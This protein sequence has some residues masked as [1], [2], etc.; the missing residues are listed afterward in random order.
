M[1]FRCIAV[2]ILSTMLPACGEMSKWTPTRGGQRRQQAQP[3]YDA[4]QA[5]ADLALADALQ[6][7]ANLNAMRHAIEQYTAI[8]QKRPA[9]LDELVTSGLLE[10]LPAPPNGERYSY[11]PG[12]GTV[13][14]IRDETSQKGDAR[15]T[16]LLEM[17]ADEILHQGRVAE[18]AAEMKKLKVAID[19]FYSIEGRY[20]SS[21]AELVE[22]DIVRAVP[23]P[24]KGFAYAYD[25]STGKLTLKPL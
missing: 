24:P 23:T 11:D 16:S 4:A 25:P 12:S 17:G 6:G 9:S 18:S 13:S 5:E 19:Y 20:P 2:F 15:V 1:E 22:R 10:Q 7:E 14:L 3:S 21:L 8:H